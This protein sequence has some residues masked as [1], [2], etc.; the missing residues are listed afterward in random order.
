MTSK[1]LCCIMGVLFFSVVSVTLANPPCPER[2]DL[3]EDGWV[4]SA[5]RAILIANYGV[6]SDYPTPCPEDGDL[7]YDGYVSAADRAF[8]YE[9]WGECPAACDS[10]TPI[11]RWD[12]VPRQWVPS[13][14]IAVGVVAVSADDIWKV[15]FDWNGGGAHVFSPSTNPRTGELEYWCTPAFAGTGVQTITAT[16]HGNCG[17]TRSLDLELYVSDASRPTRTININ[18]DIISEM[19]DVGAGGIVYL[20]ADNPPA[21]YSIGDWTPPTITSDTWISIVGLGDD[22][23]D[24]VIDTRTGLLANTPYIEFRNLKIKKDDGDPQ[25]IVSANPTNK[26]WINGV[27]LEGSGRYTYLPSPIRGDDGVQ[28]QETIYY[29]DST[30]TGTDFG[31]RRAALVRNVTIDSISND[32]FQHIPFVLN[33]DVSDIA[34]NTSSIH[35]DLW[36]WFATD[37]P[38][39]V[40]MRDVTLTDT[41]TPT[42][43]IMCRTEDRTA[44]AASC[45]A[46]LN[47]HVS[48]VPVLWFREVD[49]FIMRDCVWGGN[50][51]LGPDQD[52]GG[53][54]QC[55]LTNAEFTDNDFQGFLNIIDPWTVVYGVWTGNTYSTCATPYECPSGV[56]P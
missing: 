32:A 48:S 37:G 50:V 34:S 47:V 1:S 51:T 12:V 55:D 36:Q 54:F 22:P 27:E 18:G 16:I 41:S 25:P 21:H 49:H 38:N 24:V 42:Q 35:A 9:Y 53:H 8:M 7:T 6:C 13:S 33:C 4:S 29:T 30:I 3:N 46:F 39:N 17:G 52:G 10:L 44:P 56:T 28:D 43:A 40:I 20:E 31:A 11:A 5:D 2:G 15:E 19:D 23:E 45:V 26:L 14:G